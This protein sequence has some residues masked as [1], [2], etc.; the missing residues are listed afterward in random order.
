MT[1]DGAMSVVLEATRPHDQALCVHA[2]NEWKEKYY[3]KRFKTAPNIIFDNIIGKQIE[4]LKQKILSIPDSLRTLIGGKVD[5]TVSQLN[6]KLDENSDA[7]IHTSTVSL[8][9]LCVLTL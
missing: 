4:K 3:K 5:D 8:L 2:M 9:F 7:L 1:V 6:D